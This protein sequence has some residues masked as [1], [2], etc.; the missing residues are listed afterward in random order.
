M[1]ERLTPMLI[2]VPA[3]NAGLSMI[4][5]IFKA[6]VSNEDRE[7]SAGRKTSDATAAPE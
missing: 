7:G 5:T 3:M 6:V 2:V 4:L 1:I